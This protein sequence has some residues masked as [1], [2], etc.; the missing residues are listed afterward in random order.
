ML[1]TKAKSVH[2]KAVTMTSA[3][4]KLSQ[5][6]YSGEKLKIYAVQ[7]I[8]C[9]LSS[10]PHLFRY[11]LTWSYTSHAPGVASLNGVEPSNFI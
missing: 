5:N 11:Q 9:L 6:E 3:P 4:V 8:P 2:A 7:H 10:L 1:N